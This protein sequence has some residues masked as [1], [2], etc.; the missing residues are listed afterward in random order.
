MLYTEDQDCISDLYVCRLIPWVLNG[1]IFPTN[2]R[3]TYILIISMIHNSLFFYR[4][5]SCNIDS[6]FLFICFYHSSNNA[7]YFGIFA[8]SRLVLYHHRTQ[9]ICF[10][11]CSLCSS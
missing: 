1:E 6:F 10:Y 8:Y 2:V 3:G 5:Y 4:D 11:L 7:T 9:H